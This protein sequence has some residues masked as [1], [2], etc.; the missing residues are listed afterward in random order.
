[1]LNWKRC[2]KQWRSP[3]RESKYGENFELDNGDV[4]PK[5][6]KDSLARRAAEEMK[7]WRKSLSKKKRQRIP[8]R[9]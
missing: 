7:R 8:S 9:I 2:S 6:P 4:T 1:M 3:L 5:L